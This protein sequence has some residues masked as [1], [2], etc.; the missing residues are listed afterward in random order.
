MF[1]I[2]NPTDLISKVFSVVGRKSD[3]IVKGA[4]RIMGGQVL[5]LEADKIKVALDLSLIHI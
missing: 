1:F 3:R 4:V 2:W 5:E